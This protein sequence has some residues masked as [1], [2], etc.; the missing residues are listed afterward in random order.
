MPLHSQLII[1]DF[2][3]TIFNTTKFTNAIQERLIEFNI[4]KS[5]FD[6]HRAAVKE[7]CRVVD[8]DN[9]VKLLPHPDKKA[10]HEAIHVVIKVHSAE[11]I[12]SDVIPFLEKYNELF[13]IMI[14]THGDEELQR[15][16]IT[17]S[18]L[19]SYVKYHISLDPKAEVLR[20]LISGYKKVYY[21]DDKTENIDPVK[22]AFPEIVT[23][24]LCRPE[25]HPYGDRP[26]KCECADYM[27]GGLG[28]VALRA[29]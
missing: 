21:F 4:S 12:F 22:T 28:E 15:E 10:L 5:D 14:I 1:L 18:H 16:K 19:P 11:F 9:F 25:D 26:S 17:H 24:F 27:I 29:E 7:C 20:S 2:D 13:D 8:I 3:H 6:K 23:Y